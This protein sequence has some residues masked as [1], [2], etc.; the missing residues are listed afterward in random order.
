MFGSV[1]DIECDG[2]NPTK[3]HCIAVNDGKEKATASYKNMAKFFA[4]SEVLVGHNI[5]RFDVPVV[6]RLLGIKV[7]AFLIDTLAL[8]WYLEPDRAE[9]GLESYGEEFGVP[10]PK[11]TDWVGLTKEEYIHRCS[12]DVKI[13]TL[14]WQKQLKQLRKMYPDEEELMRFLRYINFKMDCAREQEALKWKLDIPRATEL[15]KRLSED[16][17]EAIEALEAILPEVPVYTKKT[18]PVKCFKQDGTHSVKG[19][20][21]FSLLEELGEPSDTQEV[22][23]ISSYKKPNASSTPQIKDWLYSLGWIPDHFKFERNKSTGEVRQI[24]QIRKK[25]GDN[26]PVLTDSVERLVEEHPEIRHLERVGVVKHRLD[27]VSGFLDN[28]D[29][30]GYLQARIQGLTNTLRFKHR[31]IVNL[32]GVDKPYGA[33][34]RGCLIAPDGYE[35]CGSDCSSLEDRTKQHYM[36][37]YDPDYVKEMMTPDFDPHIDLAVFAKAMAA[38]DAHNYK[39][40]TPEFKQSPLYKALAGIRKQYKAVNYSCVYGAGGP[41][42]ARGAGCSEAEGYKLVDAYW[43]RNWSVKAIAE[44]Q[45]VRVFNKR[46]WLYNPVSRFWY[47]LR[48]EKDRFSTLNQGT[49]VYCFDMWVQK[50][51][52]RKMPIIGQFHDEII[53]LVRKG[54]REKVTKCLKWAIGEVNKDLKLNRE[55]DV[56]VQFGD[57]YSAIH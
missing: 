32:P 26:E 22:R 16:Y 7:E 41:T 50:V 10:K 47:S 54:I 25:N 27:V 52:S 8:S 55:L 57:S 35:L 19:K 11:V 46:K 13:N 43:L 39:N 12:E 30:D 31:V 18:R 9:H 42:V 36:W 21:W 29:E 4:S 45:E 20:E 14:L 48:H 49:G 15:R 5:Q 33:D 40:P 51:R 28:V 17:T 24:P 2:F 3:I 34:L 23:Y 56:D 38:D 53:A 44:D 37:D 6:E 1:F